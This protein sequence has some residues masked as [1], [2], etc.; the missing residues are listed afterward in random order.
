MIQSFQS[1]NYVPDSNYYTK[2]SV[3]H[4]SIDILCSQLLNILCDCG[5][6]Y[7]IGDRIG[8]KFYTKCAVHCTLSVQFVVRSAADICSVF[9]Q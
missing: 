7:K 2:R 3:T 4:R 8:I 5:V 6:S 9:C 1:V